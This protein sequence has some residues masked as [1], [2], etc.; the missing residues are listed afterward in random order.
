M[1][2]L[3][4]RTILAVSLIGLP[5]VYA[6]HHLNVTVTPSNDA[7]VFWIEETPARVN[8]YALFSLTHPLLGDKSERVSKKLICG[9]GQRLSV[10]G[11]DYFCDDRWFATAKTQTHDGFP[12]EPFVFNGIIPEGKAF[13]WGSHPD[14]FDSRYWGLVEL[15]DTQQLKVIW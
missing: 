14:S 2:S 8:D 12:L 13:A 10:K 15:S 11:L 1:I 4:N 5:M 3:Q 6:L 9:P 7:R